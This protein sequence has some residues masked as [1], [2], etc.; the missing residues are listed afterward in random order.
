MEP[1]APDKDRASLRAP[2]AVMTKRVPTSEDTTMLPSA[3][4]AGWE[5]MLP[6]PAVK[7]D[8]NTAEVVAV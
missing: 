6:A 7:Y 8:Q 4:M 1:Y 5:M 2:A 3:A